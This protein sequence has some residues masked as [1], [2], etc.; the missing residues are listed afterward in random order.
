MKIASKR[1]D[2]PPPQKQ[3]R[4]MEKASCSSKETVQSISADDTDESDSDRF[5][6]S[7][8]K[9]NDFGKKF[10]NEKEYTYYFL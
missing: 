8:K 7:Q 3:A 9:C 4:T 6:C 2:Q 1:P 5:Q 10:D